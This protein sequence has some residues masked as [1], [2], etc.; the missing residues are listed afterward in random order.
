MAQ[1]PGAGEIPLK[2]LAR[3]KGCVTIRRGWPPP[4]PSPINV[5]SRFEVA[6]AVPLFKNR[7]IYTSPLQY[8]QAGVAVIAIYMGGVIY[9]QAWSWTEWPLVAAEKVCWLM[10]C[11]GA[12][13]L[14]PM[15]YRA[16]Y[17]EAATHFDV[18]V[19]KFLPA[20]FRGRYRAHAARM[21]AQR[22]A[23]AKAECRVCGGEPIEG[24]S[25]CYDHQ[26]L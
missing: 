2:L 3:A 11:V 24:W 13:L 7:Y 6:E 5:I 10:V 23:D 26:P 22:A 15:P 17:D 16:S 1:N 8:V 14:C 20:R 25:Y 21:A 18:L 9:N 19:I 4:S 12:A